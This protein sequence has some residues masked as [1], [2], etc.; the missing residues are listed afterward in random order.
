MCSNDMP[1]FTKRP[2]VFLLKGTTLSFESLNLDNALL[3]AIEESGYTTPTAIQSQAIPVVTAGHDLMASAQ[4][5]TGKTAAFMLPALNLLAT[6]HELKS[7]GPRILVLV[8]TRELATQVNEAARKYGKFIRARTVSIVGGMPYPLQNKLL[9]Q[10]LDIL[11]ATPGRLLDHMER[12]RIDLSRLQMLILDEADRMLDMGFLPDVERICE[13]LSAERQT[14]L[15]SATLDGDIA[16][17]AK[18][19]LKNPKTIQVAGQKEK[20]ANIEQR[21]HYVDDMTHKNKL[22]E[23]LLIAPEVNQVIIFTST[24]RHCDVL[25]EDLYA[26][27]H[28]TAALHGDMTQGARNRT[29][30]K[31][32]QG[33]VKVLVATDVAA[34]GIDINGIS[35]VIN[36]DL[37]KFAEDYVHRIGRTGRA[38]KTGIAISF[39][40]NMDRHILRKIEQFT[41]NRMEPGVV[42]GFEPK[43][44][45]KMDGPGNGRGDRGDIRRDAH[46]PGG[47]GGFKPRDDRGG[48]NN[49]NSEPRGDRPSFNRDSSSRDENRGNRESAPRESNGN[50]ARPEFNRSERP[51]GDRPRSFGDRNSSGDRS[52]SERPSGDRSFGDRAN[53]GAPNRSFG[54]SVAFGKKPFSRDGASAPR[55]EGNRGDRDSRG[56]RPDANRGDNRV[57]GARYEGRNDAPRG[58][59]SSAPSRDSRPARPNSDSRSFGNASAGGSG[60]PRRPRS[61]A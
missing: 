34:R 44:A 15:F 20:H 23:H 4:T 49:R 12:G 21:L 45:M 16:R 22:L 30:T 59:R 47:R 38:G 39:A 27:G 11:V 14:L 28:K 3:R 35:H 58:D 24:K 60:A 10:P 42:E 18:Q 13:Q 9:S 25:A 61:F 41:G 5:G 19:I 1:V 32:R 50:S 54:D 33:D 55:S 26:A 6:P 37:P 2:F 17:V 31:L 46:K 57:L 52:R 53:A 29:L 48:F 51:S 8:P 40:S 43:R 36:Y 7:R 56:N